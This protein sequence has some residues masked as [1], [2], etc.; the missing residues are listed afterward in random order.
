RLGRHLH[1]LLAADRR[2]PPPYPGRLSAL[3]RPPPDELRDLAL[4][5]RCREPPAGP[6]G[7]APRPAGLGSRGSS[8]P[9]P[10]AGDGAGDPALRDGRRRLR[11]AGDRSPPP[12]GPALSALRVG[13]DGALRFR[14]GLGSRDATR[15][16][17]RPRLRRAADRAGAGEEYGV[18]GTE[19]SPDFF[20]LNWLRLTQRVSRKWSATTPMLPGIE[21][22]WLPTVVPMGHG[23]NGFAVPEGTRVGS[24]VISIPGDAG[25]AAAPFE[26][27]SQRK[28]TATPATAT[29]APATPPRPTRSRR[30]RTTSGISRTG[31]SAMRLAATP[32]TVRW[33]A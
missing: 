31:V 19:D 3:P 9:G 13:D 22:T 32:D 28:S 20:P 29:A 18:P 15:A 21:I 2:L 30:S 14:A 11:G 7:R 27:P 4:R 26:T 17:G 1:P 23:N 8:P 33:T 16:G 25:V 10:G 6:V 12:A 24:Q 5:R